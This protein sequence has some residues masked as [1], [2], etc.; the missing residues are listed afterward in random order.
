MHPHRAQLNGFSVVSMEDRGVRG[1]HNG[2]V[3]NCGKIGDTEPEA[4]FRQGQ[5]CTG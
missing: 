4:G 5:L 2:A 3:A 1:S